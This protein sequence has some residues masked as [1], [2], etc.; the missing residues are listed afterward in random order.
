MARSPARQL[1]CIRHRGGSEDM[2]SIANEGFSVRP[3]GNQRLLLQLSGPCC[4]SLCAPYCPGKSPTASSPWGMGYLQGSRNLTHKLQIPHRTQDKPHCPFRP[5]SLK[6]P[7]QGPS[8]QQHPATTWSQNT[9]EPQPVVLS[10]SFSS[11]G[12]LCSPKRYGSKTG[13]SLATD[14]GSGLG[15]RE[16]AVGKECALCWESTPAITL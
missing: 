2:E 6:M 15:G 8:V 14:M 4:T 1:S 11:F 13:G 16:V 9:P 7:L 5:R 12:D 3:S 10:S